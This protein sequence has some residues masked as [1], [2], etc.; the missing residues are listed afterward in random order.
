[1]TRSVKEVLRRCGLLNVTSTA[2]G[3]FFSVATALHRPKPRLVVVFRFTKQQSIENPGSACGT[4]S[5]KTNWLRSS[6]HLHAIDVDVTLYPL[7]LR[8]FVSATISEHIELIRNPEI[9]VLMTEFNGPSVGV[10][11]KKAEEYGWGLK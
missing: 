7:R 1:L 11:L 5:T 9:Q 3:E 8:D 6:V 2:F 4:S 10:L